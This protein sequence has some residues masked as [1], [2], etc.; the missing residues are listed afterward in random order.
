M[1]PLRGIADIS[2]EAV[3]HILQQGDPRGGTAPFAP[4]EKRLAYRAAASRSLSEPV[5]NIQHSETPEGVLV[6]TYFPLRPAAGAPRVLFL[7]GGGF[8]SGDLDTHDPVCRL[9]SNRVGAPVTAVAYRLAPEFRYP[10][11]V[12]DCFSALR[13]LVD[14]DP[15]RIAVVGDSAGGNLAAVLAILARDSG[16]PLAAQVLIYPMLDA[17]LT[18]PS[19][20]QNALVPPFTLVDCVQAWQWYLGTDEH[21]R[22][23]CNVSPL[24]VRDT[25]GLAPAMLVTAEFDILRDEGLRYA[26]R[27]RDG[28]VSVVHQHFSEMVHG[29]LQWTATVEASRICLDRIV[30]FVRAA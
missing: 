3:R 20:V 24:H 17:L 22:I 29:F 4:E 25:R 28:G 21:S 18:S 6:R 1:G 13:W 9:L 8:L 15:G 10:A 30:G 14:A 16:I 26:G 12:D 7:H 23:H 5:G 11:A 27:L 19:L 2:D